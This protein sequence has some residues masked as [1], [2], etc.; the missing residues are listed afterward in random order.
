MKHWSALLFSLFALLALPVAASAAD[1]ILPDGSVY[2]QTNDGAY[3]WIPNVGTANALGVDWNNLQMIDELPGP[4]GDPLPAVQV[5]TTLGT[6]AASASQTHPSVNALILP[7]GSVYQL[8]PDGTCHWIPDV[9]TANALG[10]DW[11]NLQVVDEL[12]C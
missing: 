8:D 7:D 10:V 3:H 9:A 5:R 11:N 4:S 1:V 12:P 6:P 2:R